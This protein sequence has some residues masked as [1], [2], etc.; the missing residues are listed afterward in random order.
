[1]SPRAWIGRSAEASA[2]WSEALVRAGWE[3]SPLPLIRSQ[4]LELDPAGRELLRRVLDFSWAFLASARGVDLFGQRL[5][6]GRSRDSNRTAPRSVVLEA[7]GT[8]PVRSRLVSGV[9]WLDRELLIQSI[10]EAQADA[11]SAGGT[12]RVSDGTVISRS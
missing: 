1:M 8:R 5:A 4:E 12:W 10:A 6:E 2:P 7:S 11:S 9:F 3:A